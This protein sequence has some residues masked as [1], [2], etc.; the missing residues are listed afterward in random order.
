MIT[1]RDMM[2]SLAVFA[3]L[4]AASG[5]AEAQGQ[6]ANAARPPVFKHD[7]PNLSMDGWEVTV[8]HV[9]YPPG[10]VGA[11][12]ITTRGSC[13]RTHCSKARSSRRSRGRVTKRPTT[14]ARCS[15]SSRAR[16]TRCRKMREPD[17]ACE[18]A[19][20]DFREERGDTDDARARRTNSYLRC[21][22]PQERPERFG[23]D[24]LPFFVQVRLVRKV[25]VLARP[26]TRSSA[27]VA[28]TKGCPPFAEP[29]HQ[30]F[31]ASRFAD[32]RLTS[33]SRPKRPDRT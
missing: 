18:A 14:S 8:S 11:A 4:L 3:E 15:T 27:G 20:D 25:D 12:H 5:G 1:R 2:G 9:E 13:S 32:S 7:L 21:Q 33:T 17:R 30:A 24:G 16:R 10:R 23:E 31:C 19:G 22:S 29:P 6:P 26:Y 28:S